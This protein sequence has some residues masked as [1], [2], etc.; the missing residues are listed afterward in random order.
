MTRAASEDR[1]IGRRSKSNRRHESKMRPTPSEMR[2][3]QE[4]FA[5][6]IIAAISTQSIAPR[7]TAVTPF[8]Q[9]H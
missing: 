2:S 5:Q 4:S 6:K 8:D 1:G 9:S 3:I 7:L